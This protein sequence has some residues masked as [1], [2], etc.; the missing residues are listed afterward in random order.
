M[1]KG[2]DVKIEVVGYE[3]KVNPTEYKSNRSDDLEET[4][5]FGQEEPLSTAPSSVRDDKDNTPELK[6]ANSKAYPYVIEDKKVGK[7]DIKKFIQEQKQQKETD[8]KNNRKMYQPE[9]NTN[10]IDVYFN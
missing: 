9:E 3:N 8:V 10:V 5:Q 2:K 7:S 4:P 1:K 6:K